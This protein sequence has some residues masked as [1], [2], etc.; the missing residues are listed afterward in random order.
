MEIVAGPDADL[1]HGAVLA[2]Q[3]AL[4]LRPAAAGIGALFATGGETALALLDALGVNSIRMLDEI[5]PGVP[6]GVTRGA[7]NV[8]VITKAGAF[9]DAGTLL[10][11]LSH[12]R[13][14]R[15][16]EKLQ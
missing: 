4:L 7:I 2:R 9:G 16:P 1:A 6:L 3:L 15:R 10:R 11:C 12:L 13:R 8:P 14:Q 5:E